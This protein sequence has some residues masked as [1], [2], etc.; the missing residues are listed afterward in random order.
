MS[1][2]R[3]VVLAHVGLFL[4]AAF[5]AGNF[6][7]A[8]LVMPA[9]VQPFAFIVLRVVAAA[10]LFFLTHLAF[11]RQKIERQDLGRLLLCALTGVAANQLMFFKGLSLTTPIHGA[12]IMLTTPIL[13]LIA[14]TFMLG[15]RV[16]WQKILGVI[17]GLSGAS[18]LVW[19]NQQPTSNAANPV[20]GDIFVALN[21]V[22]YSIYLILVKPLMQKYS[23]IT[24]LLWVFGL[25]TFMVV[26]IGAHEVA[27]IDFAALTW[28]IWL[29][30][31]YILFC[32]T[33]LTY[34]FNTA[35]LRIISPSVVSAY[36]YLQPLLTA[37][38][39]LFT[40]QDSVNGALIA[41]GLLIFLGVYLSSRK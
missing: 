10:I 40:K 39:A 9:H 26:P 13:V 22:S 29:A 28:D 18:L 23:P 27:Q 33:F 34:L 3:A 14:A 41:S 12:L 21:A 15:E 19:S 20:L 30:I 36:I 24:V 5:Y 38:I 11:V 17:I 16:S 1:S 7:I 8:K 37:I 32:V 25:G 2:N 31:A 35:A 6:T 4:A